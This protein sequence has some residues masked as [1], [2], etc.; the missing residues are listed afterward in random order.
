MTTRGTK[1]LLLKIAAAFTLFIIVC[2]IYIGTV[3]YLRSLGFEVVAFMIVLVPLWL[4]VASYR[5][6]GYRALLDI[7]E[8][9]R[10]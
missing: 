3:F 9:W 10:K 4:L 2:G 6:A 7:I 1:S 8:G 5:A